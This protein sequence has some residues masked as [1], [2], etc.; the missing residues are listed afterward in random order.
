MDTKDNKFNTLVAEVDFCNLEYNKL[1]KLL[2]FLGENEII[3]NTECVRKYV[4]DKCVEIKWDWYTRL[5]VYPKKITASGYT[6]V[7]ILTA[8]EYVKMMLIFI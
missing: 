8:E 3:E 2:D 1:L 5:T 6:S 7:D 4:N